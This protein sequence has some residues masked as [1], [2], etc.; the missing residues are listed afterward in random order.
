[1]N[2]GMKRGNQ[3]NSSVIDLIVDWAEVEK[4]VL[5]LAA[6][7]EPQGIAV[8]ERLVMG[9]TDPLRRLDS[10]LALSRRAVTGDDHATHELRL[11]L[12]SIIELAPPACGLFERF[13]GDDWPMQ[14]NTRYNCQGEYHFA[15][16]NRAEGEYFNDEPIVLNQTG[17]VELMLSIMQ[18]YM[19]EPPRARAEA[20]DAVLILLAAAGIFT[21][22]AQAYRIGGQRALIREL[23]L[24]GARGLLKGMSSVG[25]SSIPS[26]L[27]KLGIGNYPKSLFGGNLMPEMP[28]MPNLPGTKP[29]EEML[30]KIIAKT[31]ER[32]QWDPDML[33]LVFP[34]W[35]GDPIQYIPAGWRRFL[36]CQLEASRL[37]SAMT[38][39][40]P[41]VRPVRVTWTEGITSMWFS[42]YCSG[43][44]LVINGQGFAEIR[45]TVVLLL[46]FAD[47][48]HPFDV[49][50]ADW[51]DTTITIT[52]PAGIVSGP[53]GF[54][55]ASY[56]AAYAAWFAEQNRI[57]EEIRK[58][59]CYPIVGKFELA[60]P[61][62]EC[63]PDIGINHLRAGAP[64]INSFT[65][66]GEVFSVVEPGTP[67]VLAWTIRNAEQVK[68]SLITNQGPKFAGSSTLID[69]NGSSYDLGS[70]HGDK[71]LNA[72]YELSVTGP[73]GTVTSRVEVRLRKV[74]EL[75][76][77]GAEI[78]QAIQTFRDPNVPS[79][80]IPLVALKDTI[81]RV[82]VAVENLGGFKLEGFFPD[83]V[84]ISGSVEIM[85]QLLPPLGEARALPSAR[86]ERW[87]TDNTLNFLIPAALATGSKRIRIKAWSVDEIETP[88][89]GV[90]TRP[91][92]YTF[93][94]HINWIDKVPFKVRYVRISDRSGS[95]LSD[96]QAREVI[97]RA[98]DLLATPPTD[99]AP[100]RVPTWHT[101]L[102]LSTK[103][104]ISD[105]LGHI[106]DQHDCSL[107]EVIFS[108]AIFPW[109]WEDECPDSDGAVW[110]GITPRSEWGGMAQGFR[111]FD[112]SR[113]TAIVP[114]EQVVAA[115]EMGHT[116]KLNHVNSNFNC[117]GTPEGDYD[118][119][120][121]DGRIQ[122]GD[123]FNPRSGRVI[124]N[125]TIL[126]D[127]MTYSCYRW[128]SRTN[129]LRVFDKF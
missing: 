35:Q 107:S 54:A 65:V 92:T 11:T 112:E 25:M 97:L 115:H 69:P 4:T 46:P 68:L 105:L 77:I 52:L 22:L 98:F 80:S 6:T 76:I 83:E 43:D 33:D 116:L 70:F 42:G 13:A 12:A 84:K 64:I 39:I 87:Q 8:L 59:P 45:E 96:Q 121:N 18:I 19:S 7:A 89:V 16:N 74:P 34:W 2:S 23:E 75:K 32:K 82:Y 129:W 114:P 55:D 10:L 128:V 120:P 36:A 27:N 30:E 57:A 109:G 119:L 113:N 78:T 94:H 17:L 79:N 49:P 71:P 21:N 62:R 90:K 122:P 127:F 28:E 1:M 24:V 118:V 5:V 95:E 101:S 37:I 31:K 86:I 99:I 14:I 103:D 108:D 50:A 58:L 93:S 117:T 40:P 81:V 100:A 73:C 124:D 104:G 15:A 38:A 53:V 110:V 85:G 126:Y 20:F 48:C 66:N 91:V 3:F 102:D 125:S 26:K 51:T 88:P 44:K 123:A 60:K 47:G 29:I 56:V 72:I 61:F 41:P 67:V 111:P 9:I 106:D 63:P